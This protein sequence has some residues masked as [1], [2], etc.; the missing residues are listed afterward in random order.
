M[1]HAPGPSRLQYE[2]VSHDRRMHLF[3]LY[4]PFLSSLL[5]SVKRTL[6][7]KVTSSRAGTDNPDAEEPA[8]NRGIVRIHTEVS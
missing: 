6:T 5:S 2:N 4:F 8:Q 1:V 3:Y 7:Q